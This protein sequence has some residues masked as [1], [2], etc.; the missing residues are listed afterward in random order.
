[1]NGDKMTN[2]KG[3]TRH[4]MCYG[5][6]LDD[7]QCLLCVDIRQCVKATTLNIRKNNMVDEDND[8]EY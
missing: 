2:L 6:Y 4:R 7:D 3:A 1:M 5:K 8:F